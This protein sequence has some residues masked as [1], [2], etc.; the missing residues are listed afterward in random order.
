MYN[1]T[2]T[3]LE[4]HSKGKLVVLTV[5][6]IYGRY[7]I[8]VGSFHVSQTKSGVKCLKSAH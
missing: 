6:I 7:M 4:N 5:Y 1:R 8:L 3:N 2:S